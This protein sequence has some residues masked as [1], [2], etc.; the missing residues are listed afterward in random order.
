MDFETL[1]RDFPR[2]AGDHAPPWGLPTWADF[3]RNP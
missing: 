2:F 3:A 1:K